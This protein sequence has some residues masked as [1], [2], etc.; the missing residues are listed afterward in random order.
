MGGGLV[1]LGS[2]FVYVAAS[3]PLDSSGAMANTKDGD[4]AT[5]WY[6]AIQNRNPG[7]V[8]FKVL[9]ICEPG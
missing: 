9:A 7:S 4:T 3:G 8:H 2:E 1:E 5:Q 6:A